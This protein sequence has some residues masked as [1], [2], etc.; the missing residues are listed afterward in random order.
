MSFIHFYFQKS[1]PTSL[2]CGMNNRAWFYDLRAAAE[3]RDCLLGEQE[4]VGTV[5]AMTLT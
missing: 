4:Y 1:S 2:G 3:G 5:E